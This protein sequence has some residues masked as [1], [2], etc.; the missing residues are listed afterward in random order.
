ALVR[1]AEFF[2]L[3]RD[4]EGC[5][6]Y[7]VVNQAETGQEYMSRYQAVDP[8]ADQWGPLRLKGVDATVYVYE[9]QRTLDWLAGVLGK[10]ADV[11]H[12]RQQAAATRQAVLQSM[13]DPGLELFTDVDPQ[14]GNR[15]GV[16]CAAGFY[17]FMTDI[18]G[19]QHLAALR[20]HLFDPGEFWTA[21]PVP[22]T[23][24]DD[25]YFNAEAEWKGKR[26]SCPWNGR[27]W[28]MTNSHVC[29][30][31]AR[32][33]Q[34]LDPTLKPRAAELIQRF[35]RMMFFDGDPGRPNCFEHYNPLT[36]H[37]STYR[38]I[39]D[40]QHSWVVDLLVRYLAGLQPVLDGSLVIDPLP[41]DLAAFQ[42][43]NVTVRGHAAAV[44]WNEETGFEVFLDG[45]KVHQSAQRQRI[46]LRLG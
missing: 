24:A 25:A 35:V 33:S 36:G 34:T 17:P 8:T 31:L 41:F 21:Y 1:Y 20:R 11:A 2:D 13:W 19:A 42:L 5:H 45:R 16:K 38:G 15:T 30:A 18:A 23:S 40:Y 4:P 32:A 44:R 3:E 37:P 6:L 26:Q 43:D 27:V 9:L 39:D 10:N 7:D 28:P 14:S 12:W 22:A 29:E 46:E